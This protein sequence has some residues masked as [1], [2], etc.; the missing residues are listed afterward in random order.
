MLEV[1]NLSVT[2]S[3]GRPILTDCSWSVPTG[4]RLGLIGESGS[5]KSIT[6]LAIMGLLP[7]GMRASGSVTLDGQELLTLT[8]TERQRTRGSR[9]A[10]VFQEP[11]TALDPLMKVGR[12]IVGPLRLHQHLSRRQA[13]SRMLELLHQVAL[14][15]AERIAASYPWQLSGGQRQRVALAMVLACQPEVII[16]DE[17][18][19]ALDV[20]VQAEVLELLTTLVDQLGTTLVFITHDLPVLAQVAQNL[21]VMRGGQVVEQT[22]VAN[23]LA[24]PQAAYTRQLVTAAREVSFLP[25]LEEA[26]GE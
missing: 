3:S 15:D 9:I 11:L 2:T 17:P 23:G 8:E 22:T 24:D 21:V 7:E 18:T 13:Q 12:Q 14:H 1:S 19:T 5:G 4:G 20:T 26:P 25:A 10:M 16:A 6:A